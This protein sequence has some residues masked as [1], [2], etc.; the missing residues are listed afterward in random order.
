M[1]FTSL[2]VTME[3]YTLYETLFQG[4]MLL[5]KASFFKNTV[6]WIYS[7]KF[8]EQIFP[9]A[10]YFFILFNFS[11]K[12]LRELETNIMYQSIF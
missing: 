1:V 11:L 6:R 9:V 4:S 7:F 8:C 2:I 12:N 3:L 5:F 10:S